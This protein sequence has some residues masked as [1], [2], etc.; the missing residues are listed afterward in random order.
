MRYSSYLNRKKPSERMKTDALEFL[1][2]ARLTPRGVAR[3]RH[4]CGQRV[5][6]ATSRGVRRALERNR[7]EEHTS[8][9][10]SRG[11]L[12]CRLLLEKKKIIGLRAP[13]GCGSAIREKSRLRVERLP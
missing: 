7:S 3:L 2:K 10:Q 11:D 8:E 4:S 13:A 12:V 6:G 9:L 1:S 5:P